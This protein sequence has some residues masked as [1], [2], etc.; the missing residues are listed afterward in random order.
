MNYTIWDI[1]NCLADDSWRISFIDWRTTN[2]DARYRPYHERCRHDV[3]HHVARFQA[4]TLLDGA[5]PIF[6]TARPEEVRLETHNWL[7]RELGVAVPI[8]RMR[9]NQAFEPSVRLKAIMLAALRMNM[10][11]G[12]KIVHAFDDREDICA[13][14]REANVPTTL[15][16]IHDVCAYTNP[17]TQEKIHGS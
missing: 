1:D 2:L 5:Q 14:Y 16:K 6:F 10:Q 4:T 15:L 12:D 3:A 11:P 9:A 17:L 7:R 13:M 8:V